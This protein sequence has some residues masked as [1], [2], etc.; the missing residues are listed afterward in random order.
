MCEL[1]EFERRKPR[2]GG[3][4][5]PLL[6]S[7]STSLEVQEWEKE[8]EDHPDSEYILNVLVKGFRVG[9]KHTA[10]ES[11]QLPT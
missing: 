6:T 1:R 8:L 2:S 11:Q 10:P 9:F 5:S 7:V 3:R 4:L